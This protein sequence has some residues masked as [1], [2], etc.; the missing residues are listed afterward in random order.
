MI[1]CKLVILEK[2]VNN[3]NLNKRSSSLY[4]YNYHATLWYYTVIHAS[5]KIIKHTVVYIL[6]D[7][8][9][10]LIHSLQNCIE[11]KFC[12]KDC[13]WKPCWSCFLSFSEILFLI[14]IFFRQGDRSEI[15][16]KKGKFSLFASER[17]AKN[18][19]KICLGKNAK[20][21]RNKFSFSLQ[22]LL[23]SKAHKDWRCV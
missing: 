7:K 15:S 21:S 14:P 6:S 9:V 20:F 19:R 16:R 22:T 11:A 12:E 18:A 1:T 13:P 5:K 4:W 10:F 23:V 17:N 3:Q 8:Q 2:L